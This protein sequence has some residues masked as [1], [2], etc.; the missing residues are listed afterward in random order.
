MAAPDDG[1][2]TAEEFGRRYAGEYVEYIDGRVVVPR[3]HD[4]ARADVA[5]PHVV[6]AS[7][8]PGAPARRS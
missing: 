8:L 4:P 6:R 1:P 3:K 7:G 5:T 2:M